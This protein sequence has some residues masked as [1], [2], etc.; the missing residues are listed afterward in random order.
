MKNARKLAR[1]SVAPK[2]FPELLPFLHVRFYPLFPCIVHPFRGDGGSPLT[3]D[4]GFDGFKGDDQITFT[5]SP[6]H[7]NSSFNV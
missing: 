3:V 1:S 4:A 5:G 6:T 7:Q 2:F